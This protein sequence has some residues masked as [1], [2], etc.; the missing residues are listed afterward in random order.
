MPRLLST[1]L[2]PGDLAISELCASRLDGEVYAIDEC[3]VQIGH[4][5]T[6]HVR[7]AAVLA[8]VGPSLVAMGETALW[9]RGYLPWPPTRHSLCVDRDDR[10]KIARPRRVIVHERRLLG[11]DVETIG[12]MP[13]MTA[14][15]VLFDL[16]LGKRFGLHERCL[17]VLIVSSGLDLSALCARALEA[18]N[19]PGKH[20]AARRLLRLSTEEP[21]DHPPLTLYTS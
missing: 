10:Q 19:L 21:V 6:A 5:E 9:I 18:R 12:G 8:L 16:V 1:V 15:R 20:R 3:F 14:E 7:G 13:T 2:Y 4:P 17:A 11:S